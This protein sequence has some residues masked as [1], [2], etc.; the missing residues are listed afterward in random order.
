MPQPETAM[1]EEW[2]RVNER[3]RPRKNTM[4]AHWLC[5]NNRR[6]RWKYESPVLLLLPLQVLGTVL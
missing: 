4:L 5:H 6:K 2:R 3:T 1:V